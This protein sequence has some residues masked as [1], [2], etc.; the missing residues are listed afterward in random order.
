MPFKARHTSLAEMKL[1]HEIHDLM[2]ALDDLKA[3]ASHDTHRNYEQLKERAADILRR[4]R[5]QW[6]DTYDSMARKARQA[7]QCASECAHT[8][9]LM[10]IALGVAAV[11]LIGGLLCTAQH[12]G[13]RL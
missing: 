5:H 13:Q 2:Q 4:S 6:D 3:G 10:T 1:E 8:H 11:A 7:S 12:R 9:P